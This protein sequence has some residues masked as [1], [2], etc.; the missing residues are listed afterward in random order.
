MAKMYKP[1]PNDP[2]PVRVEEIT[3]EKKVKELEKKVNQLIEQLGTL[4][5]ELTR[6][7]RTTRK[8]TNEISSLSSAVAR[9]SR[10]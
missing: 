10:H 6:T 8:H 1:D 5:R 3:D 4:Q 7:S 9:I 2:K